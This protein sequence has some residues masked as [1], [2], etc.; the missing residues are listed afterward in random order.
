MKRI[1]LLL[2]LFI[3]TISMVRIPEQANSGSNG[4]KRTFNHIILV[5]YDG[6]RKYWVDALMEDGT[7]ANLASLKKEGAEIT[8]R[9][10]DHNPSTDPGMACI[11][12]GYGPDVTGIDMNYFASNV[13]PS[14]PEGLTTTE[15]IKAVYSDKWK[16]A[17]IMPWTQWFVNVTN[18]ADSIFWNQRAETD[19]WFSS[20]NVT[21]SQNDP[22]IWKNALSFS[23]ALLRAN[24]T[25]HKAAEFIRS[26]KGSNFY[27]RVHFVEPDSVGH[28]Y[29]ESVDGRISPK[30]KQALT[31][32]DEALGIIIATLKETGIYSRTVILVST[33]HGFKGITHGP[34]PYPFG[35]PDITETWL[36]SSDLE[37]TNE[38]GWGLQNDISPTCLALAGIDPLEF[39][40]FYNVTSRALPLWKANLNNRE[41]TSPSI[42]DVSYS[43]SVHEGE[44][45]NITVKIQD[46]SGISAAQIRYSYGTIWRTRSLNQEDKILYRGSL[47]PFVE[48]T[49]VRWY[50]QVVDNSTSLNVAYYPENKTA[51]TFTVTERLA[52]ETNPP[53]ITDVMYSGQ[54]LGGGAFNVSARLQ[55]ESGIASVEI[56]Y[57]SDSEWKHK[58]LA[59]KGDNIYEVSIRPFDWRTDVRWYLNATD[60][61]ANHN[62][63]FYP[64]DKQ[65]LVFTM[66]DKVDQGV[67]FEFLVAGVVLAFIVVFAIIYRFKGG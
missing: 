58:E 20:E 35:D 36:V 21:W 19:C 8:L 39:Q 30:Y 65:P 28:G 50:L 25:A 5:T 60:N 6:A 24:F 4:E 12:S 67:P 22:N 23:S 2:T 42:S 11:E 31:E 26:N 56:Y 46:Q 32:C 49:E 41:M 59:H 40:P 37:V 10:T 16:T 7:L 48:G 14:I 18:T 64:P 55:D 34:P 33:D 43:A 44:S 29:A 52:A 51:L 45:F 57:S 13:K 3:L 63:A 54:V 47:G 27:L 66:K 15:R 9:I 1:T 61:S 62:M 38:L 17:L 53:T